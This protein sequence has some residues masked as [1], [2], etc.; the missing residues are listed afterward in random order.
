T[1]NL[2]CLL[3][4]S[5]QCF[6]QDAVLKKSTLGGAG[7][8]YQANNKYVISQSIG[9]SGPVGGYVGKGVSVL[10]GFQHHLVSSSIPNSQVVNIRIF[11]NPTEGVIS[12]KHMLLLEPFT[13]EVYDSNGKLV[14]SSNQR[15]SNGNWSGSLAHLGSGLYIVKLNLISGRALDQTLIIQ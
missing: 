5:I 8:V 7:S 13:V 10:Q 2:H 1:D 9:Q 3:L 6:S 15:S 11:P 14:E 4:F 12:M